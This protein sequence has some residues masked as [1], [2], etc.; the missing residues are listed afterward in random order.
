MKR[1]IIKSFFLLLLLVG[2]ASVL[3]AWST[4]AAQP[5]SN[6]QAVVQVYTPQ[7]SR[8]ADELGTL[9]ELATFARPAL[10]IASGIEP[11]PASAAPLPV[12]SSSNAAWLSE[13]P[14]L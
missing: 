3:Y 2:G 8:Q 6:L 5:T 14:E 10:Q 13:S 4:L 7:H 11:K 1:R 12:S 9:T